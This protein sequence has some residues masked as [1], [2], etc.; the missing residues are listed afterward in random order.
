MPNEEQA[1]RFREAH[2]TLLSKRLQ[3]A[4]DHQNRSIRWLQQKLEERHAE[5]SS[6]GAVHSY[7]TGKKMPPMSFLLEAASELGLRQEWLI[8]GK[9]EPTEAE[10]VARVEPGE[11]L[12]DR[13]ERWLPDFERLPDEA[14]R[15]F[16]DL[17]GELALTASDAGEAAERDDYNFTLKALAGDLLWLV[18]LPVSEEIGAGPNWGFKRFPDEMSERE[19]SRYSVA[20]LHALQCAL[21]DRGKSGPIE[22]AEESRLRRIRKAVREM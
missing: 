3:K 14:Q 20:M 9:G 6:Y 13:M 16:V 10:Q 2:K 1:E 17:L 15:L 12:L 5:Y 4:L 8:L 7:V 21:G 19:L 22:D 18:L 11:E